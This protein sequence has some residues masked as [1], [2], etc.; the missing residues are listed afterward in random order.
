MEIG[1]SQSKDIKRIRS[2]TASSRAVMA[3]RRHIV[4]PEVSG[5]VTMQPEASPQRHNGAA[6]RPLAELL[7]CP[8][9][10]GNLLNASAEQI[11]F[12]GGEMVFHQRDTC[13]GLYVVLSGQLLRKAE[14]L[15]TRLTLGSVRAGEVVELAAAL[16]DGR[17]TYSLLA[18]TPGTVMLLPMDTLERAFQAYPTLR[19]KL[20]E[21]LAR[22]VSRAY[23]VCCVTRMAGVRRRGSESP[24]GS[25]EVSG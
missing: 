14:R 22:E 6:A 20:L 9:A 1:S 19:M 17:H 4:A 18:Q 16:G 8:P 21:E 24:A 15:E 5:D 7:S 12:E 25:T 13:R 3:A 23:K 10:V 2:V 11:G